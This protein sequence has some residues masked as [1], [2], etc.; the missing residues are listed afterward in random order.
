MSATQSLVGN[1]NGTDILFSF[2]G[3][4]NNLVGSGSLANITSVNLFVDPVLGTNLVLDNFYTSGTAG[5][6]GNGGGGGNVIGVPEPATLAVFGGMALAG[7]F[8][9]RRRKATASV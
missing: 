8:G 9:Y 6:G 2:S 7:A 3:F 1:T 4:S 5:G